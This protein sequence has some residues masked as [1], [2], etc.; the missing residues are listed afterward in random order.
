[1]ADRERTTGER[2][3]AEI[4]REIE[5]AS[6]ERVDECYAPVGDIGIEISDCAPCVFVLKKAAL[7]AEQDRIDELGTTETRHRQNAP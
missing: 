1:M 6:P 7:N 4:R 5:R 3:S 2:S